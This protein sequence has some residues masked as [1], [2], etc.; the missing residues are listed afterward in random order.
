MPSTVEEYTQLIQVLH[1]RLLS[2]KQIDLLR[3]IAEARVESTS[4][5]A[6]EQTPITT[7]WLELFEAKTSSK[8]AKSRTSPFISSTTSIKVV[9]AP[10]SSSMTNGSLFEEK[11]VT[12]LTPTHQGSSPT[13]GLTSDQLTELS[14]SSFCFSISYE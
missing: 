8:N 4:L 11:L 3:R 6:P 5:L 10:P 1:Q 14:Y 9:H 12:L 13:P 2:A 7:A